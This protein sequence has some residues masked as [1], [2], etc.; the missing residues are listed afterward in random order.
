MA[1]TQDRPG[2]RSGFQQNSALAE[3]WLGRTVGWRFFSPRLACLI[4]REALS[5]AGIAGR[6]GKPPGE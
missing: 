3:Q 6:P 5:C 2:F 1:R 4:R